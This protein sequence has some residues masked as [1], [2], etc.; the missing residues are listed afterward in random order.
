MDFKKHLEK[1]WKLTLQH[2]IP[3]L[4]MTLVMAVLSVVT[5]GILAPVMM[6]GYMQALLL[7]LR[8]DREPKVQ[9]LFSQMNLF[10]PLLG[11]G[12]AVLIAIMIGF[13]LLVIPGI[14]IVIAVSFGCLYMLPLMTDQKMGLVDAIKKS[15]EMVTKENVIEH[16]IVL[17]IFCGIM[18][19]GNVV[20][21][22][23]LFT[24][25]LSTVFLM[26]VFLE[27]SGDTSMPIVPKPS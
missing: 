25:P 13:M 10:L 7:V 20:I 17:V 12:I 19:I 21:V 23:F 5:L 15:I 9:D 26:S 11:F 1:A 3:L 2:I 6:A 18:W 24:Q 8:D 27:L 16:V 22:G 4:I 14:L